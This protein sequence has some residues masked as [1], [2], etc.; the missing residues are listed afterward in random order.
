MLLKS[1][2]KVSSTQNSDVKRIEHGGKPREAEYR[3]TSRTSKILHQASY[4]SGELLAVPAS[5]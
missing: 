5:T 1:T 3:S 2:L 4:H